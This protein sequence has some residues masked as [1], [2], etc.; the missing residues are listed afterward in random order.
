MTKQ[1]WGVIAVIVIIFGGFL[2]FGNNK[3]TTSS[4]T[5]SQ[6]TNHVEGS[7]VD[8]VK[9]V[10]YGDFECP[11]CEEAYPVVQQVVAE[12]ANQIQ[13]QFRNFPLTSIHPNAFAGARAAEAAGLEG[14][15]WQMHDALY[16]STNWQV[17][18]TSS[19]PTQ[20]FYEYA[21]QLGLNVNQFKTDFASS[22]VN[23]LVQAD[24]AAGTKLGIQG[25]PTFYLNGKLI[26]LKSFDPTQ[27]TDP[28]DALLK[29]KGITP[30]PITSTGATSATTPAT[31]TTPTQTQTTQSTTTKSSN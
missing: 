14:K 13:F 18:S 31:T 25:T 22:K 29:S 5:S 19:D 1:F 21:Q 27:F 4:P 9:L 24:L 28:I 26:T 12:Y 2:V 3:S 11:Y 30:A 16:D 15:Y 17:W 20:Y 10:E 7:A 23:D 8:S 6:P